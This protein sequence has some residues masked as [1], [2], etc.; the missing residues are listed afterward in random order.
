MTKLK[1]R[2]K[3]VE[4]LIAIYSDRDMIRVS[5]LETELKQLNNKLI[6]IM[7]ESNESYLRRKAA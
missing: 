1:N 6:K 7:T 2:I 4:K 3:K 5:E